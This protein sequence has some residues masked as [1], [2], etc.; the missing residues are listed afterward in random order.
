MGRRWTRQCL[1]VH[2]RTT[3]QP[4]LTEDFGTRISRNDKSTE[5]TGVTRRIGEGTSRI[6]EG[7]GCTSKRRK[8][9]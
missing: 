8:A 6:I 1:R 9:I 5:E 4:D 2:K 7:C 3:L